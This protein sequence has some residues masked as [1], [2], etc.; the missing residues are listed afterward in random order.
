MRGKFLVLG[1]IL[2]AMLLAGCA[3]G[4]GPGGP[5]TPVE[6]G[7]ATPATPPTGDGGDRDRAPAYVEETE[8]RIM[9]SYPIQVALDVEGNLPT[10]CHTFDHEVEVNE[11]EG[12]IDVQVF[13]RPPADDDLACAQVLEPF[14]ENIRLGS[15]EGGSF[16]VYVNGEA[17]GSFDA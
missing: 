14:D 6:R 11:A 4:L 16:E 3:A 2:G 17:I 10:P 13:S 1:M 12:R 5:S 8:L 7:D 9:E 15:F